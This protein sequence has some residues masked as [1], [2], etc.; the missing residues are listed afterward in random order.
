MADP[1]VKKLGSAFVFVKK[2]DVNVCF[3]V[4]YHQFSTVIVQNSY[5]TYV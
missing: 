1:A 3:C 5:P 2:E 4:D